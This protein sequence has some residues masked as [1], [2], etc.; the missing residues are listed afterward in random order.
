M[1]SAISDVTATSRHPLTP[2]QR[3]LQIA[4]TA[5]PALRRP[6][7]TSYRIAGR[8][9]LD[10][11]VRALTR[12]VRDHDALR[13][14][15]ARDWGQEAQQWLRPEPAGPTVLDARAEPDGSDEDFANS[16]RSVLV[17]DILR[18]WDLR[19]EYP[20]RFRLIRRTPD[21]HAFL[22]T[23][24][25]SALDGR[26][27]AIVLRD[28]WQ[29]YERE[30]SGTALEP[31]RLPM[32]F[33]SAAA[34]HADLAAHPP[35]RTEAFWDR[36]FQPDQE[37][38]AEAA[39]KVAWSGDCSVLKLT[40]GG[41]QLDL[42]RKSAE[43]L[44]CSEFQLLV[45]AYAA[46]IFQALPDNRISIVT[47]VDTRRSRERNIAGMFTVALPLRLDRHSTFDQLAGQ[48]TAE[49]LSL[50]SHRHPGTD[51]LDRL[52]RAYSTPHSALA[53]RFTIDFRMTRDL[54]PGQSSLAKPG[55]APLQLTQGAYSPELGYSTKGISLLA[56]RSEH[57]LNLTLVID[58]QLLREQEADAFASVL[59]DRLTD[60][61]G[62]D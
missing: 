48:A 35:A 30:G 28:V 22:A 54:E 25:P 9:D 29:N 47:P 44:G 19:T 36:R 31:E 51:I 21:V 49:S 62:L 38:T 50:L 46:A 39:G 57:H 58:R 27:R 7:F 12:T 15:I 56:T 42:V 8:L 59:Q 45:A 5:D 6:V 43:K 16:A 40:F 53:S 17:Q 4:L 52:Y 10:T 33:V 1:W 2:G 34:E 3:Q 61:Q 55:Q 26:G 13:I 18:R 14:G 37:P 60:A 32:R 23:F 11:L 41:Q 20:F 24:A